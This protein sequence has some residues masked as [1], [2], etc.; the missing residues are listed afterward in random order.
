MNDQPARDGIDLFDFIAEAWQ[1]KW[2]VALLV[3]IPVAVAVAWGLYLGERI[4]F[5]DR[6]Y[7]ARVEYIVSVALD[8]LERKP[9]ELHA[10]ML[11]RFVEIGAG[12]FLPARPTEYGRVQGK[13]YFVPLFDVTSNS[14]QLTLTSVAEDE[15][16]IIEAYAGLQ[17]AAE[18]QFKATKASAERSSAMLDQLLTGARDGEGQ[19]PLLSFLAK[20]FLEDPRVAD[21]TYRL[22]T[23]AEMSNV[24]V[25][26]SRMRFSRLLVVGALIG[27]L[28]AAAA[29]MLRI[30]LARRRVTAAGAAS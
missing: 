6:E 22:S 15:N 4:R 26:S 14:V 12:K 7:K 1:M 28:L 27:A 17:K 13:V 2:L 25:D 10:D 30:G 18:E 19:L 29:V 5:G 9:E 16:P 21:G 11:E 24:L 3:A 8:P 23:V 20:R